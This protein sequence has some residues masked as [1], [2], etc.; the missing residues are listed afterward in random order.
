MA[1][2]K[3]K[4]PVDMRG[5][6]EAFTAELASASSDRIVYE[7]TNLELVY[8]GDFTVSGGEVEGMMERL[9]VFSDDELLYKAT[10]LADDMAAHLEAWDEDGYQDATRLLL[11]GDDK[12]VG[13]FGNDALL[14]GKGDDKMK[15]REGDDE[16]RGG[17]GDDRAKGREGDDRLF[18]QSGEDKLKGDEGDDEL[19]G[20]AD[21]DKLKGGDGSDLLYGENG[22][23][24]LTGGDGAD[25]FA[26]DGKDGRDVVRDFDAREDTIALYKGVGRDD[27]TVTETAKGVV[28]AFEDTEVV[29]RG[30][31]SFDVDDILILG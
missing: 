9:R 22:D 14:G 26:F 1:K 20:G 13:S 31:A 16:L 2:F 7:S 8:D 17:G 18:G 6:G 30:V 23:D 10:G 29:L 28:L 3:F 5:S 24:R 11:D 15:G 21:D 12:V 27:V 19:Y 25:F 4:Q